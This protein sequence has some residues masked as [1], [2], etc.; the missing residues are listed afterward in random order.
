MNNTSENSLPAREIPIADIQKTFGH[1]VASLDPQRAQGITGLAT[2]RAAKAT[3]LAQQLKLLTRKLGANDPR[4]AALVQQQAQ[5]ATLQ[6]A[7]SAET[8]RAQ[9]PAPAASAESYIF[10]G[11]VFDAQRQPLP[12]LSVALYNSQG[13]WFRLLGYGCTDAKGYFLM[14]YDRAVRPQPTP[15]PQPSPAPTPAPQPAPSPVPTNVPSATETTV[16]TPIDVFA[17]KSAGAFDI[18]VFD[19]Q[20][21]PLYRDSNPLQPQLGRVDYRVIII[22]DAAGTCTPPPA[23]TTP[24]ATDQTTT[25]PVRKKPASKST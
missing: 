15:A 19:Q 11:Y 10:H 23:T 6:T 22:G 16:V 18:L 2:V 17:G 3:T 8:I 25:P 4:I 20:Q 7:I 21:K 13:Q 9:A 14:R 1:H 5:N 12:K 24:G